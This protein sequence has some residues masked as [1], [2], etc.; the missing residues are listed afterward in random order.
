[1]ALSVEEQ[2]KLRRM[3]DEGINRRRASIMLGIAEATAHRYYT[4]WGAMKSET[5]FDLA[6][7]EK[8]VLDELKVQAAMRRMS[9]YSYFYQLVNI[10]V[11]DN[12]SHAIFD[13]PEHHPMKKRLIDNADS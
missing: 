6:F 9:L 11:T 2:T 1:M 7:L 13:M 8:R 4:H 5:L 10:V 3:F 12:L